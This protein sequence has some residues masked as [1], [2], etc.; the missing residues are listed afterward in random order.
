VTGF[1]EPDDARVRKIWRERVLP[2]LRVPCRLHIAHR[3]IPFG[4]RYG[5]C[6]RDSGGTWHVCI[7]PGLPYST[8]V[9]TMIHELAHTSDMTHGRR[10][11]IAYAHWYRIVE[12]TP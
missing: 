2:A 12:R 4:V 7:R 10:W 8:A 5:C 9:D 6:W 3:P 1:A 11:G